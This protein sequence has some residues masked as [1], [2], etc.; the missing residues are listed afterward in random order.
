[1]MPVDQNRSDFAFRYGFS[2]FVT[3]P[4]AQ[5]GFKRVLNHRICS[6]TY[7]LCPQADILI[8]YKNYQEME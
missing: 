3:L 2:N 6:L 7:T 8:I 1:M 5:S 4:T